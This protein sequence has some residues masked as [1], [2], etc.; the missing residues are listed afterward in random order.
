VRGGGARRNA[1][2]AARGGQGHGRE[3]RHACRPN[4]A[5]GEEG[6]GRGLNRRTACRVRRRTRRKRRA[7][8]W[9]TAGMRQGRGEMGPCPPVWPRPAL[10]T[11]GSTGLENEDEDEDEDEEAPR[12]PPGSAGPF[13]WHRTSVSGDWSSL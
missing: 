5:H 1:R 11:T 3:G 8:D 7:Q 6:R 12:S 13:S 9:Q 10:G 4:E 2:Q